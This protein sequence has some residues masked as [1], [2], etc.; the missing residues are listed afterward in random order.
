MPERHPE[1]AFFNALSARLEIEL[2]E[3]PEILGTLATKQASPTATIESLRLVTEVYERIRGVFRPLTPA[4]L[5]SLAF[6][7][8]TITL[9]GEAQ[10]D[11]EHRAQDGQAFTV[12]E[13]LRAVE[14]TERQTRARSEWLGGVDVRHCYFEGIY[15][16]RDGPA[17]QIHWGS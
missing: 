10:V 4:E 1:L 11:V 2:S 3:P 13:L 7:A 14:D 15:P 12:G 17:W 6:R 16:S 9:R 8:P 5:H